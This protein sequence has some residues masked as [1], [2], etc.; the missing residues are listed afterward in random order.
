MMNADRRT[1][2]HLIPR[3]IPALLLFLLAGTVRAQ[4]IEPAFS[5]WV[6]VE[7]EPRGAEVYRGDSLLGSTPLRV[8]RALAD[9]LTLYVPGRAVWGAQS[10][11]V[12][13]P[14]PGEREGVVFVRFDARLR[15]RSVPH[16][17]AVYRGDSLL[18]HTPLDVPRDSSV[19]TLRVAGYDD[20]T[21]RVGEVEDEALIVT[22]PAMGRV[23][24]LEEWRGDIA[25]PTL[26]VAVP[27]SLALIAGVASV[28]F[29]QH[30]DG[31]YEDYLRKPEGALLSEVKK[32]DIYAGISLA[33]VQ[34]GLGYLVYLL[35]VER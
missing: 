33:I 35:F 34:V 27:A 23:S 25:A 22:L 3:C 31:L 1:M 16:G 4:D 14:V 32:Y 26:R 8:S 11:E 24:M 12:R 13:G 17:A 9:S 30:A 5:P 2:L 29:K 20:V 7:S 21:V 18:G 10:I 6:M 15:L 28:M 19:L